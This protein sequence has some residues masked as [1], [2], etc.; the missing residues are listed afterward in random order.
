MNKKL[1]I[2]DY[3]TLEREH[4]WLDWGIGDI[5]Q[6]LAYTHQLGLVSRETAVVSRIN[7]KLATWGIEPYL[8]KKLF[9][10]DKSYREC[11]RWLM[12]E[13]GK[14]AGE[15][16]VV[17]DEYKRG[18]RVGREL[19]CET[20]LIVREGITAPRKIAPTKVIHSLADLLR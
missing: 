6:G 19:G 8:S 20:Y 5:V 17:D 11:Y 7:N 4:R 2:L 10:N 12:G 14:N 9:C 13:L 16:I 1:M 18:V 15:T 3:A